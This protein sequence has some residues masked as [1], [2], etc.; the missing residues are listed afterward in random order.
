MPDDVLHAKLSYSYSADSNFNL[1]LDI[2]IPS[3]GVTVIFGESG[4]GKTSLLRCIAGLE[5]VPNAL[6]KFNQQTW[7][8]D[9]IFVPTHKRKLAYVFQETSLFSHLTVLN[10]LHY[11]I[12]RSAEKLDNKF[13]QQVIE[14]MAIDTLLLKLPN[15]L[16]GG[17]RQRVAIARALLSKPKVLLMDEPLA[18]LDKARKQQILPYLEALHAKFDI[19]I[20]YVTHSLDEMIRLAD[21]ALFMEQGKVVAKGTL[22][23]LFGRI[24][25]PLGVTDNIGAVLECEFIQSD[26]EWNLT[27]VGFNGG[28]LWLPNS[29]SLEQKS[30]RVRILARDISISLV[31][32]TDISILNVLEVTVTH[33]AIEHQPGMSLLTLNLGKSCLIAS[34]TS[35]S[36]NA[37]KI[38]QGQVVWAMIKSVAIVR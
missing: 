19:P 8:E 1:A 9:A 36:I 24:D 33:I 22:T 18:S 35:K 16:S 17:E 37:L 29:P 10:N 5:K 3:R 23:E 26:K 31:R 4:S 28:E 15:Q 6:I 27:Q 25:T 7:Q 12:K 21:Y 38:T 14:V 20:V 11:A 2:H 30:I 13:L 32:P 34:L